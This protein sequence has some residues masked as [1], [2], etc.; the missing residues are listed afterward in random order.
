MGLLSGLTAT[1]FRQE[2]YVIVFDTQERNRFAQREATLVQERQDW[3][4]RVY[5]FEGGPDSARQVALAE[6]AQE[7]VEECL[8]TGL[9]RNGWAATRG[10]GRLEKRLGIGVLYVGFS[11]AGPLAHSPMYGGGITLRESES[12]FAGLDWRASLAVRAGDPAVV[13]NVVAADLRE[14]EAEMRRNGW[15]YSRK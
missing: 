4:A 8:E 3:M 11:V 15:R 7:A 13:N 10:P 5:E 1:S 9:T 2:D 6:V 14:I 12:I